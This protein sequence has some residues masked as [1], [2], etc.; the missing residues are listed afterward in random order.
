LAHLAATLGAAFGSQA[1]APFDFAGFLVILA[2]THLLFDSAPLDQFAKATHRFLNR[3]SFPQR[4]FD[5][6]FLLRV[7]KMM[8][9]QE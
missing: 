7:N 4:Q 6:S 1:S 9:H 3:L 5:H 2:A 8:I